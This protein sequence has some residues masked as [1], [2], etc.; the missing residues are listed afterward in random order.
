MDAAGGYSSQWDGQRETPS[1]LDLFPIARST[2]SGA[3]LL[4]SSSSLLAIFLPP[5][6]LLLL[7]LPSPRRAHPPLVVRLLPLAVPTTA[8]DP[9]AC[10]P[11]P[12]PR[13]HPDLPAR[14]HLP[15]SRLARG[16]ML[17]A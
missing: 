14:I 8:R 3:L 6:L 5:L 9:V 11:P 16:C 2:L 17:I 4:L 10:R 7:L 12:H 15:P 13:S 1:N